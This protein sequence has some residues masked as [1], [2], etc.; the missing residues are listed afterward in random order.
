MLPRGRIRVSKK[1]L[2]PDS[3]LGIIAQVA[4]R[5][6]RQD[7][8]AACHGETY[9]GY[10]L[11]AMQIR[12]PD[13]GMLLSRLRLAAQ[14]C[15]AQIALA[16]ND[17]PAAFRI[18][19][20][21][22]EQLQDLGHFDGSA[23]GLALA[24]W[25]AARAAAQR[26]WAARHLNWGYERLMEQATSLKDH[27]SLCQSLLQNVPEHRALLAAWAEHGEEDYDPGSGPDASDH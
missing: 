7:I 6:Q 26:Q 18:T 5:E 9:R 22:W 12:Q 2:T 15:M 20:S 23:A 24:C 27:P 13:G 11:H 21:L 8:P 17:V 10:L 3:I 4:A 19:Q 14:G 1:P 16:R 25:R